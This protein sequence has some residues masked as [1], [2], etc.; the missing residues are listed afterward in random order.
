MIKMKIIP[1]EMISK[2]KIKY[3][4]KILLIKT[5]KQPQQITNKHITNLLRII[6]SQ[7]KIINNQT[8]ILKANKNTL[9]KTCK[10]KLN[11]VMNQNQKLIISN[12]MIKINNKFQT[13]II[14]IIIK[15]FNKIKDNQLNKDNKIYNTT[16]KKKETLKKL[17]RI[18]TMEMRNKNKKTSWKISIK[19]K[20]QKEILK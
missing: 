5:F 12:M 20:N 19:S 10:I 18:L 9:L 11:K 6:I 13:R 16:N 17:K 15:K 3:K 2:I 4:K 14:K 8:I 1:K 7:M